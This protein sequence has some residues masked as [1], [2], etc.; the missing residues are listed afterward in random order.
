V[1]LDEPAAGLRSD[2]AVELAKLVR[3]L[4]DDW[5]VGVLVVEHDMSFVM[6]LC[7]KVVVLDFGRK[8]AEGT[9]A[10]IGANQVVI[11]AYLGSDDENVP[12]SG[13]IPSGAPIAGSIS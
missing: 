2:E 11:D 8:I 13:A 12:A 10:E 4:A 1:L 5:G 7:D 3:R 6:G 9:P